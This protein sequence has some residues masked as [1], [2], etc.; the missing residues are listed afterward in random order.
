MQQDQ[1]DLTQQHQQS[2]AQAISYV[3]SQLVLTLALSALLLIFGVVKAYSALTGGLIATIATAWFAYKVF[4][5]RPD[6]AAVTML[7]SAYV[8]EIYKIFLTGA[9]FIC[10]FVLIKPISAAALLITYF[11]IYMTPALQSAISDYVSNKAGDK[12][13]KREKNG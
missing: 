13:I 3:K 4:R 10:A 6:S 8:G 11:V 7:A 12:E 5:V 9:L 1:Q 2:K